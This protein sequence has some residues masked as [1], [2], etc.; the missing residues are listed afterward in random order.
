VF[1]E[2]T[3]WPTVPGIYFN[4]G[5]YAARIYRASTMDPYR[6]VTVTS[7]GHDPKINPDPNSTNFCA[8]LAVP[9]VLSGIIR[10]P[11]GAVPAGPEW[12]SAVAAGIY[13]DAS[14]GLID[15]DGR[16]F[17]EFYHMRKNPQG[18]VNWKV[19]NIYKNDLWGSGWPARTGA[20]PSC[21]H[22]VRA[23]GASTISGVVRPGEL[24]NGIKHALAASIGGNMI[25]KAA[26]G[27]RS[28][29]WPATGSDDPSRYS[30]TAPIYMGS[31]LAIPSTV[32]LN[33]IGFET[34]QGRKVADAMKFYGV[35]IIDGA[36]G[37]NFIMDID[38][39][40][41]SELPNQGSYSNPSPFLR[42]LRRA[43]ALLKVISNNGPS[44]VGGGGS[45]LTT[46]APPILQSSEVDRNQHVSAL[47][48]ESPNSRQPIQFAA[49]SILAPLRFLRVWTGRGHRKR[50]VAETLGEP[51]HSHVARA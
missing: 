25:N 26:P 39:Q 11:D 20:W 18:G 12:Y 21:H 19:D 14:M 27:G 1:Q 13:P 43:Y 30:G 10:I 36:S 28:F 7:S 38:S 23:S 40:A 15:V 8:D 24:T 31:L 29:V 49:A 51:K 33:Q 35:Y 5:Q 17:W 48:Q 3:G 47:G 4:A 22:G 34:P 44:T 32:D 46:L 2:K 9:R 41:L 6:D 42:D 37:N 45:A 50:Q 16:Y